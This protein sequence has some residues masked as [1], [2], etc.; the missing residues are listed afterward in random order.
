MRASLVVLVVAAALAGFT[1]RDV[2]A[3]GQA[4]TT[5]QL[6]STSARE[7]GNGGSTPTGSPR[8][9]KRG[10]PARLPRPLSCRCSWSQANIV[11]DGA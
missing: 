11:P 5:I 8:A 10:D 7:A 2:G 6:V 4:T 3:A 1:A 9:S